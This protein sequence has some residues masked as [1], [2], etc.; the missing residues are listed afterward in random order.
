LLVRLHL[1]PSENVGY[2]L[3]RDRNFDTRINNIS[4]FFDWER[5]QLATF[6]RG[7]VRAREVRNAL[8]L[9]RVG[10]RFEIPQLHFDV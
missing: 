5:A 10:E 2:L 9:L 4:N 6:H 8:S 7:E 3:N 1:P